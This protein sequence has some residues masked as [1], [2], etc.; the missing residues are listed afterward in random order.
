MIDYKKL[1]EAHK[2]ANEIYQ[3]TGDLV[4]IT[5]TY[6]N[7][8]KEPMYEYRIFQSYA[9]LDGDDT[10]EK[11]NA[12]FWDIDRMIHHLS[13]YVPSKTKY[14][15]CQRVWFIDCTNPRGPATNGVIEAHEKCDLPFGETE[16][17][18]R[19]GDLLIPDDC[20]YPSYE[21]LIEARL[22]CWQNERIS[23]STTCK[24][25]GMQRFFGNQC[26]ECGA[27]GNMP[28]D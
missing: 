14:S 23:A 20:L 10:G 4:S 6:A 17:R 3:E 27:T 11:S 1:E 13:D 18:A 12:A 28:C 22:E 25:C 15:I 19:I 2:I 16:W 21:A 24:Q 26:Y 9:L 8:H 5:V 7:M